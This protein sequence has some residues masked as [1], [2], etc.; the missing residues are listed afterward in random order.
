[1]SKF[2]NKQKSVLAILMLLFIISSVVSAQSPASDA[3]ASKLKRTVTGTV[4]D[5]QRNPLPGANIIS[6]EKNMATNH[7]NQ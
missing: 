7:K 2:Y 5:E 6:E 3:N 4:V 1:M